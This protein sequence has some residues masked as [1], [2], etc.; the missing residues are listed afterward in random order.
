MFTFVA[1]TLRPAVSF[2]VYPGNPRRP[3]RSWPSRTG[4]PTV[5]ED[6]RL[7]NSVQRGRNSHG[8]RAGPLVIDPNYG[9]NS[10]HSVRQI[11][12]W[13]LDA[14]GDGEP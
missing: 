13:V 6:V 1:P 5:A 4:T 14:L 2:Q 7:V 8:Y 12:T 10:E 3:S 9:V 11:K